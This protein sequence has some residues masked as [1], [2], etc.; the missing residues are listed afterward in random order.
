MV[1]RINEPEGCLSRLRSI[2]ETL[3][4][5]ERRAAEFILQQPHEIIHL[6]ISELAERCGAS[7]ATIFRLCRRLGF[8]GYQG[9]KISL[10]RDLVEP[11]ALIHE[12]VTERDSP[13]DVAQKVFQSSMRSLADTLKVLSPTELERAASALSRARK[14]EFYG[15]GGSGIVALD[16]MHK[17]MRTGLLCA[18]YTDSHLQVMSAALLGPEDVAVG[19]SHSGSSKDVV[20]ALEVAR[21]AGATTVAITNKARSPIVKVASIVL[22]TTSAETGFR[23]EAMASRLCQLAIV[24]SLFVAVGLAR[25]DATLASV[26][27][28]REAIA[29]KR[30]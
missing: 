14:V 19:I 16:A 24:D 27:R 4:D 20:Q 21:K 12:E 18:A 7:E 29:L 25:K 10:A 6:P 8:S 2:L 26:Q 9:M 3:R 15:V 1:K 23:T 30:Y 5:A 11:L 13:W 28:V 22:C 17:F